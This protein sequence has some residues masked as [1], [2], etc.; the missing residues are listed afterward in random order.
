MGG[1]KSREIK[2]EL[3]V[4]FQA[5]TGLDERLIQIL[6]GKFVFLFFRP[7]NDKE[8]EKFAK[9]LGKDQSKIETYAVAIDSIRHLPE[10]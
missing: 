6:F 7:L 10:F 3:S 1:A 9:E 8:A 5:S 4:K 2:K